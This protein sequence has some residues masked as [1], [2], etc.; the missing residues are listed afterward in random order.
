LRGHEIWEARFTEALTRA[1]QSDPGSA[2]RQHA[3]T[4]LKKLGISEGDVLYWLERGKRR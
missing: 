2:E 3:V 4:D 1:R